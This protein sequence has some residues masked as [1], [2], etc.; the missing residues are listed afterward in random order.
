MTEQPYS[1]RL[2]EIVRYIQ[3]EP[4]PQA[5]IEEAKT[6]FLDFLAACSE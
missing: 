3:T 2:A 5:V 4:L 1:E 6:C